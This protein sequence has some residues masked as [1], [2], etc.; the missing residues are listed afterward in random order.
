[1]ANIKAGRK[2]NVFGRYLTLW[3]F[4]CIIAG[5]LL[6]KLAPNT[7]KYLDGFAITVNEAPVVSVPI[8]ICL[9]L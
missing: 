9:F 4:L 3:V 6:G 8:A 5:I 7:A 2:L 1:M